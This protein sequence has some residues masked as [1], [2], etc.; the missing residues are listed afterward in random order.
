[1]SCSVSNIVYYL[2]AFPLGSL[3]T[4]SCVTMICSPEPLADVVR[5]QFLAFPRVSYACCT[6]ILSSI[7][8]FLLLWITSV[9]QF[10]LDSRASVCHMGFLPEALRD[11][12]K[13][14][15]ISKLSCSHVHFTRCT[16]ILRKKTFIPCFSFNADTHSLTRRV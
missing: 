12:F 14:F 10:Q 5:H 1:M 4:N 16:H 9:F 8:L 2:W 15:C 7:L 11:F 13:F 6:L 3:G